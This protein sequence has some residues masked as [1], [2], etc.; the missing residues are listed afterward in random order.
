[1]CWGDPFVLSLVGGL[2][3]YHRYAHTWYT[4]RS[5]RGWLNTYTIQPLIQQVLG[6]LK[7]R[8][9]ER[10]WVRHQAQGELDD[11]KLGACLCGFV[12]CGYKPA[13]HW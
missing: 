5:C 3:D 8:A 1:M 12:I 13:V 2:S 4:H 10:E 9:K 11:A 6:G 7:E